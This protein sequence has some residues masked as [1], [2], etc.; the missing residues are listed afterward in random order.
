MAGRVA[1]GVKHL[2][3]KCE[4]LSSNPSTAQNKQTKKL[5]RL[6]ILG[7]SQKFGNLP[8]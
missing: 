3:S 2:P 4:A 7:A 1:Q 8:I 6:G 5:N